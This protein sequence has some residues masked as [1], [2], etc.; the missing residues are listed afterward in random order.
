MALLSRTALL[1]AILGAPSIETGFF[2]TLRAT[3]TFPLHLEVTWTSTGCV[4]LISCF[5]WLSFPF[6]SSVPSSFL[7]CPKT[8]RSCWKKIRYQKT[9]SP[10][11]TSFFSFPSLTFSMTASPILLAGWHSWRSL[12]LA[13][14]PTA[15]LVLAASFELVNLSLAISTVAG[16]ESAPLVSLVAHLVCTS[17]VIPALLVAHSN[18]TETHGS[19]GRSFKNPNL[20]G[21]EW[22]WATTMKSETGR[23]ERNDYQSPKKSPKSSTCNIPTSTFIPYDKSRRNNFI[24]S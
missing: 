21:P 22:L 10:S 2:R 24:D 12:F 14:F 4:F 5:S 20:T 7:S 15:S 16:L 6:A 18:R 11:R 1:L 3:L 23:G 13:Q 8:I 19:D 17:L 9:T